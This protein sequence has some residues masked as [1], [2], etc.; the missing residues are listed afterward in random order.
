MRLRAVIGLAIAV[1]W[2]ALAGCVAQRS[3]SGSGFKP[4]TS[5][6]GDEAPDRLRARVHTELASSYFELGN[7]P[8][9]LEETKEALRADANA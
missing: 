5:T 7:I 9:A 6:M 4:S 1:V 3:D 8:V 2:V